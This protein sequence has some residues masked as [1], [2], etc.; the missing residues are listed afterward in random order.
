MLSIFLKME[1]SKRIPIYGGTYENKE[2]WNF[3]ERFEK[4]S[5]PNI[6]FTEFDAA[7]QKTKLENTHT[8]KNRKSSA[9]KSKNKTETKESGSVQDEDSSYVPENEN[10]S[11]MKKSMGSSNESGEL[12]RYPQRTRIPTL[13]YWLGERPI[14]KNREVVGLIKKE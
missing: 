5:N 6:S 14:Y 1:M 2:L 9:S 12:R 8:Q 7:S 10:E 3:F 4:E 13:R 11:S